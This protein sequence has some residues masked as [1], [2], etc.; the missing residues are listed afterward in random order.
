M[1]APL[2]ESFGLSDVGQARKNNEDVIAILPDHNFF[3]VADGM[4][5]HKAGEVAAKEA[6]DEILHYFQNFLKK[7]VLK[8]S[9]KEISF[10]IARA[11]SRANKKVLRLG[12]NNT[13]Y[14]GMGTTLCCLYLRDNFAIYAHVGDSRIYL[15]RDG[16]LRQLTE[17]H[18]LIQKFGVEKIEERRYKN[19]ITKAIG[20]TDYLTPAISYERI[21]ERDIYLLCTDGLSDFL[22]KDKIKNILKTTSKKEI[23]AKRLIDTAKEKGSQDN[24]TALL[25]EVIKR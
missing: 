13:N 24:I 14:K 23:M 21:M 22:S 1:R 7:K 3:T 15:L 17:D 10:H 20:T 12:E 5:G 11:I 2:L 9:Q 6:T 4:G 19:I 8:L 16:E 18:S 25:V